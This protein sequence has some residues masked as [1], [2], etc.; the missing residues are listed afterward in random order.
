MRRSGEIPVLALVVAVAFAV[1]CSCGR[2]PC[3]NSRHPERSEW[4]TVLAVAVA[5]ALVS[6]ISRGFS[7]GIQPTTDRASAPE[8][9]LLIAATPIPGTN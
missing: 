2:P 6:E 1:V 7:P 4:T 9:R 3:P 8:T 5:L